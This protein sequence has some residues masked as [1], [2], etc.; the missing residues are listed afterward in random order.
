MCM[1]V[2][3]VMEGPERK[4]ANKELKAIRKHAKQSESVGSQHIWSMRLLA[5]NRFAVHIRL[6]FW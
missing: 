6:R 2:Y 3:A 5:L 4:T 1:T